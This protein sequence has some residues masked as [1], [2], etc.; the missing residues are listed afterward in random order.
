MSEGLAIL[1]HLDTPVSDPGDLVCQM[2]DAAVRCARV[3]G[4]V[5]DLKANAWI[6]TKGGVD[7]EGVFER[8]GRLTPEAVRGAIVR[9]QNGY[10]GV[11]D[12]AWPWPRE[13]GNKALPVL[14]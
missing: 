6:R 14:A 11:A 4:D 1:F 8:E 7:Y 9:F 12:P 13:L 3:D 5:E 10:D 2:V